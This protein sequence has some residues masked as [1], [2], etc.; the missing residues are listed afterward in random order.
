MESSLSRAV[1]NL[2]KFSISSRN[3]CIGKSTLDRFTRRWRG[4]LMMKWEEIKRSV[5][6]LQQFITWTW[7]ATWWP[8]WSSTPTA[9]L[10]LCSKRC[11]TKSNITPIQIVMTVNLI[12]LLR[13]RMRMKK[14]CWFLE[15]NRGKSGK[16]AKLRISTT[17]KNFWMRLSLRWPTSSPGRQCLWLSS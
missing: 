6:A 16:S 5:K 1:V 7:L 12:Y 10:S 14:R 3:K 11:S 17:S 2:G 8:R 9:W 4:R 13:M 15:T